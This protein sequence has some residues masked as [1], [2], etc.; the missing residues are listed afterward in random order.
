M[1][2]FITD[3]KLKS[4]TS[5]N[6]NVDVNILKSEII[7]AQDTGLQPILGTKFYN[8]LQSRITLTG[9]TFSLDEKE[10][11]DEYIS[12]FLIQ[13]AYFQSIPFLH[14]RT[15][16]RGIVEG[17]M[18]SATSVDIETMKYL[19]GVQK[20][21]A[22]FYRQRLLEYLQFNNHLFPTY[23]VQTN[24]DGMMPQ[25]NQSYS[26]GIYLNKRRKGGYSEND[27]I[28]NCCK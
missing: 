16:N 26:G 28:D 3:N 19:R 27:M 12:P 11:V 15:M 10:L 20:Q 24:N 21:R 23:T 14:L 18:E 4:F 8:E 7:I 9:N 13:E 5:I 1:P 17:Q 25:R 2:L 6:R 22:D